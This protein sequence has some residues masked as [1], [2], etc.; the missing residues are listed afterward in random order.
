MK[1]CKTCNA[2][3]PLDQFYADNKG[4]DGIRFE[5]KECTKIRSKD[6]RKEN[7]HVWQ[8]T[9]L[10]KKYGLTREQF[11]Q[12]K[13]HQKGKCA[14][15]SCDLVDG[16]MTC[17]DH[18]HSTGKIRG[19][20]CANCNVALGHFKDSIPLIESAICYLKGHQ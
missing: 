4:K 6:W 14:I 11:A 16:K 12:M 9:L 5:C 10:L 18:C 1:I 17:V 19:I 15:C 13:Q 2:K 3:K 20:L 7:K 8:N